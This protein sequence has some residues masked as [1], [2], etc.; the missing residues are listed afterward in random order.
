MHTISKHLNFRTVEP[1]L[2]ESYKHLLT[3]IFNVLNFYQTRD[4]EIEHVRGDHQFECLREA[5]RPALLHTTAAG[6]HVPEDERSV[7]TI[8]R[9]CRTTFNGLPYK[10]YPKIML[11][12]LV[13][14]SVKNRNLFPS[15]NGVSSTLGPTS[16][17]TG[18]PMPDVSL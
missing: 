14:Y 12:S 11:R 4:F 8:E 13:R 16:I 5:L 18:L 3:S 6:E 2:G 15:Q 17:L 9:Y 1:I 10:F 7:Q